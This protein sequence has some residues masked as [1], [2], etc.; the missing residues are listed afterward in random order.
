MTVSV[1]R[2]AMTV[3]LTVNASALRPGVCQ[4]GGPGS[5]VDFAGVRRGS[6]T[7]VPGPLGTLREGQPR[8][9][10]LWPVEI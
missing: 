5:D 8:V 10:S 9:L 6:S 2:R 3:T 4:P 1:D 7:C